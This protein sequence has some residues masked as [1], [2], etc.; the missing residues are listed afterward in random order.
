MELHEIVIIKGQ[1]QK[2]FAFAPSA[3]LSLG[4]ESQIVG[5]P[6]GAILLKRCEEGEFRG[7]ALEFDTCS[8]GD[9]KL[10]FKVGIDSRGKTLLIP[11]YADFQEKG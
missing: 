10:T 11:Y 9:D 1:K 7:K 5:L 2:P 6:S 3:L 8:A 4:N